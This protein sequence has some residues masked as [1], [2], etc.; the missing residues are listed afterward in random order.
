MARFWVV[1]S[2]G[3]LGA[4]VVKAA[5]VQG[6]RVVKSDRT[7][8]IEMPEVVTSAV[9]QAQPDCIINCAGQLPG[10]DNLA[11]AAA[12]TYGPHLL[13][14]LGIRVV[15][16][17][18]DCVFSGRGKD[19]IDNFL[20]SRDLPDPIDTYGRTKLAGEVAASNVLNVR[21]SFIGQKHGF[22]RWLLDAKGEVSCWERA[23]WNGS[24]VQ[25][26]AKALVILAEG[27]LTG[28]IHAASPTFMSKARMIE[29]IAVGLD[30]KISMTSM[31]NPFIWRVLQPDYELL[32]VEETLAQ[33]IAEVEACRVQVSA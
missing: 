24:S 1:G 29:R 15:H 32:P 31:W 20:G 8:P 28:I 26:M 3:M 23:F 22:L 33:I 7:W 12:N 13:A 2:G 9:R 10:S 21:G 11:M 25:E 19:S 18:T 30:L 27:R 17:S 16:M 5:E 4:E 14:S 6:H